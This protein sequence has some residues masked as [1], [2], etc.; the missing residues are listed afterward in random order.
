MSL[1]TTIELAA[2]ERSSRHDLCFVC[3]DQAGAAA[4]DNTDGWR[5]FND[6]R[7]G[8]L[9]LCSTCAVP[10]DLLESIPPGTSG[11]TKPDSP[12][13]A[14]TLRAPERHAIG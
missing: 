8:L 10:E 11:A 1:A 4:V 13:E 7:G 12:G 9:P 3:G 5:W 2:P 6:G 14:G